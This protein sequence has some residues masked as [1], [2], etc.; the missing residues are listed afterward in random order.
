MSV[1]SNSDSAEVVLIV[2]HSV[3]VIVNIAG[4]VL[5]C[6]II[7]RNRDMRYADKKNRCLILERKCDGFS[8]GQTK[9]TVYTGVRIKRVTYCTLFFMYFL[10]SCNKLLMLYSTGLHS[11]I[12]FLIWLLLISQQ[13]YFYHQ[14]TYFPT[15]SHTQ[16][17]QQAPRSALRWL[18]ESLDGSALPLEYFVWLL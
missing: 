17:E 10:S 4:N 7:L 5:V 11:T 6:V 14:S 9:L 15:S 8:L 13:P 2:V 12:L 18:V 1:Y 3:L 16:K